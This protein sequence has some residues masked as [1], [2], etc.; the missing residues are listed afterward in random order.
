MTQVIE[1]VDPN[2]SITVHLF[3]Q[4]SKSEV[5]SMDIPIKDLQSNLTS[6]QLF[7]DGI[8]VLIESHSPATLIF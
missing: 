2:A 1:D 5:K 6:T 7:H 3:D 8:T 4:E